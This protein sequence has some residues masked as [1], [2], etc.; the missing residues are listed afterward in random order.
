MGRYGR[1]DLERALKAYD[2]LT[3]EGRLTD[4][5]MCMACAESG[6]SFESLRRMLY[7]RDVGLSTWVTPSWQKEPLTEAR[8]GH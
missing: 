8:N 7:R 5:A 2:A 3:A 6:V 1:R 4:D